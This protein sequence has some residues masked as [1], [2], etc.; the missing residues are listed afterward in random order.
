VDPGNKIWNVS[1][2]PKVVGGLTSAC[3]EVARVLLETIVQEPGYVV[4]VSTPEAAE[5]F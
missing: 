5:M 4:V 1:N 3:V 2:T